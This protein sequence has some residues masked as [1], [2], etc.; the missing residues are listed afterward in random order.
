MYYYVQPG[1]SM[2]SIAMAYNTT[3]R[4][5]M[6]LNPQISDP[7]QVYPGERIIVS[8]DNQWGN[9][10]LNLQ[11]SKGDQRGDKSSNQQNASKGFLQDKCTTT[12]H[13]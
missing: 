13:T 11:Y 10:L 3:V 9:G 4:H 6:Y 5:L 12:K 8:N 2:H 7:Y 1:D